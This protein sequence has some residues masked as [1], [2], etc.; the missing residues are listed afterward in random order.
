METGSPEAA[1]AAKQNSTLREV[2]GLSWP[3]L[4]ELNIRVRHARY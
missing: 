1:E 3:A 2:A 4:G